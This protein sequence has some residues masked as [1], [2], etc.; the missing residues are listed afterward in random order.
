MTLKDHMLNQHKKHLG[1]GR[2]N[3]EDYDRWAQLM[4]NAGENITNLHDRW[5]KADPHSVSHAHPRLK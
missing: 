2:E 5:H 3:S 4:K 1:G